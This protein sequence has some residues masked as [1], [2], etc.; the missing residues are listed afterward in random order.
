MKESKN[1]VDFG[2]IGKARFIICIVVA[3][4]VVAVKAFFVV[5][6]KNTRL[7]G[8]TCDEYSTHVSLQNYLTDNRKTSCQNFKVDIVLYAIENIVV[9]VLVAGAGFA[10]TGM[11][12]AKKVEEVVKEKVR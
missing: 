11:I 6:I 8:T 9:F 5:P 1:K 4:L 3:I 12:P 7:E 10:I 2:K